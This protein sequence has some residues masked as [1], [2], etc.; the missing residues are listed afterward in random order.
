M[1]TAGKIKY[2]TTKFGDIIS[3]QSS[4]EYKFILT[5]EKLDIKINNGPTVAYLFEDKEHQYFIDFETDKY[6]FEIKGSH[7]WY[8]EDLKS[9]KIDAK[10]KKA[11]E[12]ANVHCKKFIFLLDIKDY[13]S[14]LGDLY[15]SK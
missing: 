13:S 9:G 10:N 4:Y 7:I 12:Y 8:Q 6:I 11:I 3:Y 15:G 2:Y 1:Q 14:V 5:C